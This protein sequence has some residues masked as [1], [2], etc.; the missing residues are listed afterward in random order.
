MGML[1]CTVHNSS[2]HLTWKNTV[3]P[4]ERIT[5][6]ENTACSSSFLSDI[7]LSIRQPLLLLLCYLSIVPIPIA[8]FNHISVLY[9]LWLQS[10][11][12]PPSSNQTQTGIHRLLCPGPKV[13]CCA[14]PTSS[15]CPITALI[16]HVPAYFLLLLNHSAHHSFT[17]LNC[18]LILKW[19]LAHT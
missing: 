3:E 7:T 15:C 11:S 13:Y 9:S 6:V 19:Q 12:Y 1:P 17:R 16:P 18:L 2:F 14:Q 5:T 10:L 8:W 4:V